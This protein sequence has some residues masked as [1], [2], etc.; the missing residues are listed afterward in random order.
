M[1]QV[2]SEPVHLTRERGWNIAREAGIIAIAVFLYFYVRGLVDARRNVAI[3]HSHDIVDIEK[4]LGIFHEPALQ[5]YF[6]GH[7]W[8]VEII[9]SVYIYGH[10]PIVIGTLIW[11]VLKHPT[12]YSRYRNALLISGGIGLIIFATFPV[13]PPRFLPEYG[14][15]DSVTAESNAYRVL[16]PPALTNPYAAM[17]SLHFGWNLLIGIAWFRLA[18]LPAGKIFGVVMPLLMFAAIILTANHYFLDGFAGGFLA[19]FGLFVASRLHH[20]R[21]APVPE[22]EEDTVAHSPS[23][24]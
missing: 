24:T 16:Q 10:W 6:T 18:R 11:L 4:T 8:V 2:S 3:A 17:P 22:P 9:N 1:P 5:G 12:E 14:F 19:T 23:P 15:W 20:R 13:A 7:E 21:K